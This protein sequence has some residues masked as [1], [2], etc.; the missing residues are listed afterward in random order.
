MNKTFNRSQSTKM[1]KTIQVPPEM[2]GLII[3]RGGETVKK[4]AKDAGSGCRLFHLKERPGTFEIAAYSKKALLFA[5]FKVKDLLKKA[6]AK[7]RPTSKP[8]RNTGNPFNQFNILEETPEKMEP[9]TSFKTSMKMEMA[10]T[11]TDNIKQRKRDYWYRK[12]GITSSSNPS[13]T[14]PYKS[15]D[16]ESQHFPTLGQGKVSKHT[17]SVWGTSMDKIKTAPTEPPKKV[18][19]VLDK[20]EPEFKMKC[21]QPAEFQEP[22]EYDNKPSWE[23]DLSDWGEDEVDNDRFANEEDNWENDRTQVIWA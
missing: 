8:I 12:N 19:V 17:T 21:Y 2:V 11:H 15:F 20:P 22:P 13:S 6:P 10:I 16:T 14:T 4:I 3:G 7:K 5:E 9:K 18:E 1:T 23:D